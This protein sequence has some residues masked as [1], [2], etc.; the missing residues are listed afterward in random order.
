MS[1]KTLMILQKNTAHF[2][3]YVRAIFDNEEN[4]DKK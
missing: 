3:R 4:F 1:P 2:A